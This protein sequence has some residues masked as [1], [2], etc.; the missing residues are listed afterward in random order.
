MLTSKRTSFCV[1]CIANYCR[2]PVLEQLLKHKYNSEYEFYSAG[3]SPI[4]SA[5]MDPRSLKFLKDIGLKPEIHMPKKI[6]KKMLNYFDYFLAIDF[7]VL[8]EL[9]NR[10][11]KYKNKF[12]LST[13]QF[14]NL[15]II[16]PFKF[17]ADE[18]MNI[19]EKIKFLSDKI[20]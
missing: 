8:N 18:Y 3:I 13:A 17:D 7:F 15:D 2:S 1:V 11:P 6:S 9:N 4:S 10:Y 14:E 12:L 16:D 19:M 5:S 20:N